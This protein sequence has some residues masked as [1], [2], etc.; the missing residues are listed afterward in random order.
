MFPYFSFRTVDS[1]ALFLQKTNVFASQ[2]P[3]HIHTFHLRM[4]LEFVSCA[5][6]TN[7]TEN[8]QS[9]GSYTSYPKNNEMLTQ[10]Q[11]PERKET[12]Q[13][14]LNNFIICWSWKLCSHQPLHIQKSVGRTNLCRCCLNEQ[15]SRRKCENQHRRN[16]QLA[17][18]DTHTQH[19]T[20]VQRKL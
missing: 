13:Y 14:F 4:H 20:A 17:A 5:R 9:K 19:S 1:F 6:N 10:T 15:K 16:S 8:R 2:V 18:R 11:Q 12:E 3:P 7:V